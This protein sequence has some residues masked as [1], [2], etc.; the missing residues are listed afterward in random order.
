MT[1]KTSPSSVDA[2]ALKEAWAGLAF[3]VRTFEVRAEDTLDFAQACGETDP[4]FVDGSHADFQA[5]TTF[6]SCLAGGRL[7][8][9]GF[10]RFG[11][12]AF[13]AGKCVTP[14]SPIRAGDRLVGTSTVHDVYEKTGRSGTMIFLVHRME[15]TNQRGELTSVVEGRMVGRL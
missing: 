11:K 4:R 6:A 3:D 2:R 15:F 5:P 1:A 8:P 7:L 12:A 13:D 9:E 14:H 10:P